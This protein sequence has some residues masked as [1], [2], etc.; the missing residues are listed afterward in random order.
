[1][2]MRLSRLALGL[3][4][5]A[6]IV[7]LGP[8]AS[9]GEFVHVS[10]SHF[11]GVH[12]ERL[13]LIGV[14]RSG[15]EYACAGPVDGGRFGYGVF[16][17]PVDKRSV[18]ALVSWQVNAVALPLNEACWLGGYAGLNPKF[19]GPRYRAAIARYV[20]RLNDAGIYVVLRLSGAAP[21]DHAYGSDTSSTN[22]IPMADSDHSVAFWSSLARAFKSNRMVLFHT[23][24]EPH[25]V[26]WDC[27]LHGCT[28][29][30]APDGN[31]RYGSY[32]T[33]GNQVMVDA[34]R[35]TGA[36]QPIILSG[37]DFAADLSG[38]Q[39]SMP[40]D[41]LHQLA[42]DISSFDY[43]DYV[44]GHQAQLRAFTRAHP[45]IVGG[46]GDTNC[47][48]TYSSKLMGIMDSLQQSY[49]AWTW[50]TV[51]DYGGCSNALLDDAGVP[52]AGQPAGY[53]S[54]QPSGYGQGI[55]DHFRT[56]HI[57]GT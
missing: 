30:D 52:I 4:V 44:V 25:D 42:A 50:N 41:P 8:A 38:W 31:S 13:R 34:I 14:D 48:S 36:R 40:H 11:V 32:Q 3:I 15:T 5:A 33:A 28:A 47:S 51:Q 20:K 35:A 27:L 16:Q 43:G 39:R 19:T 7:S 45:V 23:F 22:E 12:G 17:G 21:G 29:N 9:A 54:A 37:P 10:G 26:S 18:R 49:L 57:R 6:A 55:R 56:L 46:F 2:R 1:M 24:D 53:Y